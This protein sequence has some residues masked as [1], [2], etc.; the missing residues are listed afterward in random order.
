MQ[1]GPSAWA[2]TT[3]PAPTTSPADATSTGQ[4]NPQLARGA[5]PSV[6]TPSPEQV[7]QVHAPVSSA[8]ATASPAQTAHVQTPSGAP[9]SFVPRAEGEDEAVP[10]WAAVGGSAQQG[11][12]QGV[13]APVGTPPRAV[14]DDD[15]DEDPDSW[16]RYTPLQYLV[17]IVL[18]LILGGVVWQLLNSGT[19]SAGAQTASAGV[20][21]E[22]ADAAPGSTDETFA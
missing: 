18:G 3:G 20:V 10:Q 6:T 1:V 15:V 2:P 19:D 14:A 17:L 16:R 22:Q 5:F 8:Q 9:Q 4:F 13:F 21:V 11:Q 12:Q 7:T